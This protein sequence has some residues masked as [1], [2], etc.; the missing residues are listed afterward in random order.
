MRTKDFTCGLQRIPVMME[1]VASLFEMKDGRLTA[2]EFIP[3]EL[4]LGMS[5]SKIGLPRLAKDNS[6]LERFAE[7]SAPYGTKLEI[8]DRKARLVLK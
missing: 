4:G 8:G 6:I 3:L 1:S 7:M 5:H 2:L